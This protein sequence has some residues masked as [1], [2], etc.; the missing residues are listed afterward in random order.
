MDARKGETMKNIL[1]VII[2][3]VAMMPSTPSKAIVFEFSFTNAGDPGTTSGTVT[4]RIFGLSDNTTSAATDVI[5]DS[6]PSALGGVPTPLNLFSYPLIT[7]NPTSIST[8]SFT[9]S[10]GH[11][12]AANFY[13]DAE[14]LPSAPCGLAPLFLYLVSTGSNSPYVFGESDALTGVSNGAVQANFVSFSAAVPEP[15]TWIMLIVGFVGLG[16]FAWKEQY[17]TRF[18]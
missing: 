5:I 11:I 10:G 14:C 17:T 16:L 8:N 7:G 15:A 13:A 12:A 9:V 18:T 3:V 2:A 1:M 4:G 6:Y